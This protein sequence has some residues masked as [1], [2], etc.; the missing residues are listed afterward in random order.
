M[1]RNKC[2]KKV[3]GAAALMY[4]PPL[5]RLISLFLSA[6]TKYFFLLSP[7]LW[8]SGIVLVR[9]IFYFHQWLNLVRARFG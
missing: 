2:I 9:K 1:K 5:L 4:E 7:L 8:A 6:T 3:R